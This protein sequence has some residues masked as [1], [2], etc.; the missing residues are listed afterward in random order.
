MLEI[1]YLLIP[2]QVMVFGILV[3][4]A[5]QIGKLCG[6]ITRKVSDENPDNNAA[7]PHDLEDK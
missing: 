7:E 4:Q 5:G 1:L 6:L 3:K 2:L